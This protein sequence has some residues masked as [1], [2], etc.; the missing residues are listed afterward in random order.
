MCL[1]CPTIGPSI[2]G[3]VMQKCRN[4]ILSVGSMVPEFELA[5]ENKAEKM[6]EKIRKKEES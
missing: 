1:Q 5:G 4:H 6:P 2:Y 3:L